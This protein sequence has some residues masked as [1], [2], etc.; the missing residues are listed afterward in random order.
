MMK[1]SSAGVFDFLHPLGGRREL[2]RFRGNKTLG[3][4]DLRKRRTPS[5]QLIEGSQASGTSDLIGDFGVLIANGPYE[6]MPEKPQ[7]YQVVDFSSPHNS[8]VLATIPSV[9]RTLLNSQTGTTFLLGTGGLTVVRNTMVEN[10]FK[11]HQIQMA[12]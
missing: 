2:I 6:Y 9:T 8:R 10:D 12:N 3:V 1:L 4:L 5:I 11:T 7:N